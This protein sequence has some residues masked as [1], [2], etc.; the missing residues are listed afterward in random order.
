M[1]RAQTAS[2]DRKDSLRGYE[3]D[4]VQWVHKTVNLIKWELSEEEFLE[5]CSKITKH[6]GKT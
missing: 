5:W 1:V 2:L 4:N 6:K 3:P